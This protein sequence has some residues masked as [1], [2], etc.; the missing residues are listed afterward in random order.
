MA[1]ILN[2]LSRAREEERKYR[3]FLSYSHKDVDLVRVLAQILS[4]NGL[5]PMWDEDFLGGQNF[6]EQIRRYIAH[7]DVFL[8]VLTHEADK[9]KWVHEE[10]GYAMARNVSVL[11]VAIKTAGKVALPDEM[12]RHLHA[13]VVTADDNPRQIAQD[14]LA[15][16]RKRLTS[17]EIGRLLDRDLGS[18]RALFCCADYTEARATMIASHCRDVESFR[19]FG[20][21][22]QKGALSSFHI[23]HQPVGHR[24]WRDRFGDRPK[25]REHCELQRRERKALVRHAERAGCRI[26]IDPFLPFEEWGDNARRVRLDCLRDFLA[27]MSDDLCQVAIRRTEGLGS[28]HTYVGNWFAAESKAAVPRDG[29]H[30]TI[31]TRHGPSVRERTSQF[32]EEFAAILAESGVKPEE[33]RGRA[34]G[35]IEREIANIE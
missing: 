13:I 7:A 23:P 15:K 18:E 20:V 3:V 28:S 24:L 26:I 25:G 16:L 1:Q 5:D 29:Y 22:R 8:P 14:D 32:D 19:R 34:I 4:S 2:S 35:V 31:F 9:H 33:S 21:V 17:D 10:I 27:Q 11:P 30:Q 12:I 6:N